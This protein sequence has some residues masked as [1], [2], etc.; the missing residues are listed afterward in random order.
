MSADE[1]TRGRQN[2][3][4]RATHQLTVMPTLIKHFRDGSILE[5]DSGRFDDWCIYLSRPHQSRHA[6]IDK[7]YFAEFQKLAQTH[8]ARKIYDDFVKIYSAV[9]KQIDDQ[10][11]L[12]IQKLSQDYTKDNLE[13]E[14]LFSIVYAGMVAEQN[15]AFTK[16]GKRV[17]RL[18]MYQS[19]IEGMPAEQAALYS[20][21][22][23]WQEIE[24]E[25]QQRGF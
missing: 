20:K 3:S 2:V 19:L 6:P 21:G 14:I 5:Y 15:K 17:K 24:K 16:L 23:K 11:L 8:T 4:S 10:I 22:K 1:T 7:E 9:T 13:I 12:L 18:G 25:C